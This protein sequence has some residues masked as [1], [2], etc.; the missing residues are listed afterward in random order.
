MQLGV[1]HLI[2]TG[3]LRQQYYSGNQML[4]FDNQMNDHLI[5]VQQPKKSSIQL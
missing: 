1:E 4:R 5:G 2:L 3:S